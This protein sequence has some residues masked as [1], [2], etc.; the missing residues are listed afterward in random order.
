VAAAPL[1]FVG[2]GVEVFVGAG[3][4]VFVGAGV[5]DLGVELPGPPVEAGVAAAMYAGA[6]V[7]EMTG[8]EMLARAPDAVS[9]LLVRLWTSWDP[10]PRLVVTAVWLELVTCTLT[11]TFRVY[12]GCRG[13]E[14]TS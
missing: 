4:E 7:T 12:C 11:S 5:E 13:A 9:K 3:V 8:A 14:R 2:A 1:F 10:A 6:V